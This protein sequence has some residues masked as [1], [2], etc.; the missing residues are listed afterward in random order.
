MR[1][2]NTKTQKTK[3]PIGGGKEESEEKRKRHNL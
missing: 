2:N 3:A 1:E